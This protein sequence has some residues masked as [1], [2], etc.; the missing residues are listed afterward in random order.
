MAGA[1]TG[2]PRAG[3]SFRRRVKLGQVRGGT[4]GPLRV[5]ANFHLPSSNPPSSSGS[6]SPINSRR[7]KH[8]QH[9]PYYLRG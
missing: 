3:P 4:V 2:C 5:L 1:V 9:H 6:P 7:R 8:H